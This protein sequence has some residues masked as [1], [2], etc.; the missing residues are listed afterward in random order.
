MDPELDSI[1]EVLK[2]R[3]GDGSELKLNG[4][5]VLDD[6]FDRSFAKLLVEEMNIA[7]DKGLFQQHKFSFKLSEVHKV[8]E[9]PN[10]YERDLYSEDSRKGFGAFQELFVRGCKNISKA[11]N[12]VIPELGLVEDS[13]GDHFTIKLQLNKGAGACFPFHYDNPGPD[14]KRKITF[15]VYLNEFWEEGDGG[16]IQLM[17]F[18]LSSQPETI[19]PLFNRVV[20]FYSDKMLHRVLPS[21]KERMCFTIWLD[22]VEGNV[23]TELDTF[24]KVK[25]LE[26][27]E[28]GSK[29]E[30]HEVVR[31]LRETGLQRTVA[32][33]IYAK[34][35]E[36]SLYESLAPDSLEHDKM[37]LNV[38]LKAHFLQVKAQRENP[39][40]L[41]FL[42][43]LVKIKDS[44][45]ITL[46]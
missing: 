8:F 44:H 27:L 6:F 28:H 12:Q 17:P 37:A 1:G 43:K 23:N 45:E 15:L 36:K 5:V 20:I 31:L 16:E 34:E 25:H 11:L 30:M 19:A 38:M 42:E 7:Q 3:L 32:R 40:L 2:Q 10:I 29:E 22:A 4:F 14:N 21:F 9:K 33:S 13:T 41:S 35:F 26:M 18:L 24:L 39:S 46:Q